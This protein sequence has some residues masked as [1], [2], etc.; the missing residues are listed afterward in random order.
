[1]K[2]RIDSPAI[3]NHSAFAGSVGLVSSLPVTTCVFVFVT[4]N[5][6]FAWPESSSCSVPPA[7]VT[8]KL[9]GRVDWVSSAPSRSQGLTARRSSHLGLAEAS[10]F[11][12]WS[13]Q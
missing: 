2:S 5:D 10:G 7:A 3:E 1:V 4:V 9:G 8:V 13:H 12:G 11:V 6:A